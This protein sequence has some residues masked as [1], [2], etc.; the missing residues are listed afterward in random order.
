MPATHRHSPAAAPAIPSS[1][2]LLISL[3]HG[4]DSPAGVLA[5]RARRLASHLARHPSDRALQR[6]AG[7]LLALLLDETDADTSGY[8]SEGLLDGGFD[9]L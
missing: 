6:R 4:L 7:D 1:A 8:E 9:D 5:R 3:S 2:A